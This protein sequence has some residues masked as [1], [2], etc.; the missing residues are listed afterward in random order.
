MSQRVAAHERERVPHPDQVC[1]I[2]ALGGE[3]RRSRLDDASELEQAADQVRVRLTDKSPCEDIWIQKIPTSAREYPRP[4]L[5]PALN[6]SLRSEHLQRLA[7]GSA[8]DIERLAGCRFGA[9]Q[10]PRRKLAR[11]NR[12]TEPVRHGAVQTA[13]CTATR[14][15]P[16]VLK[17]NSVG[18]C[19]MSSNVLVSRRYCA[20]HQ[21]LQ[22]VVSYNS[23]TK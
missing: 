21:P 4:G 22:S 17:L 2:A 20:L 5:R 9:E 12:R 10:F 8:G 1:S 6:Q 15:K 3:A 11:Q 13:P 23:Q 16:R 7:V 18:L 19:Q 14:L